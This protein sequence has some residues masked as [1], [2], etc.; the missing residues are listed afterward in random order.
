MPKCEKEVND[1]VVIEHFPEDHNGGAIIL[2]QTSE[3]SGHLV[4]SLCAEH[5]S[6][7]RSKNYSFMAQM[8]DSS[9]LSH[10]TARL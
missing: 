10:V 1:I 9:K 7:R 6:G 8:E 2:F 4:L 5:I 3:V